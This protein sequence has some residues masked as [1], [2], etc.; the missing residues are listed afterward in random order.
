VSFA[1]AAGLA[2]I[3]IYRK[4]PELYAWV[5]GIATH[6]GFYGS[7]DV[8]FVRTGTYFPVIGNV[9]AA[10]PMVAWIP[11]L[12]TL[13]IVILSAFG[14]LFDRKTANWLIVWTSLGLFAL[15]LFSFLLVAKHA[16]HH[17]FI[18]IDLSVALNLVLLWQFSISG[19]RPILLRI[20]SVIL[21]IGLLGWSLRDA[22]RKAW[23]SYLYL[24]EWASE[25]VALYKRVSA[26]VPS[27][28][29]IDYYRSPSPRFAECFGDDFAG[30]HFASFLERKYPRALFY[31][32]FNG[33]FQSFSD[34]IPR[35]EVL[36]R[37][38]RLY[39]FGNHADYTG[40]PN[41][42]GT[43]LEL[44]DQGGRFFL[45]EWKRH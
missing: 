18:P 28:L 23:G 21:L 27:D 24:H 5:F 32:V 9:L 26:K 25:Q 41:F 13:A 30:R 15:Q 36:T 12:T 34:S 2:L 40:I 8:G 35:T 44:I 17:Y 31:N 29:R 33:M 19:V 14:R 39:F 43:E 6:T 37:H 11:T 7:G 42:N 10:E 45:D 38:D 1:A 22:A 3:P 16:N 20:F 4:L